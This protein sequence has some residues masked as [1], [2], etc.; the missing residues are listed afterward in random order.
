MI[1]PSGQ[2]ADPVPR[3]VYLLVG[4]PFVFALH[5]ED[6]T[7]IIGAPNKEALKAWVAA[8]NNAFNTFIETQVRVLSSSFS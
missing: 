7:V 5:S 6:T 1:C 2:A 8:I 4:R 3:F